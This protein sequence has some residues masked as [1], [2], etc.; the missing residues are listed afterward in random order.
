[1]RNLLISIR[2]LIL[3]TL[4]T[5]ILYPLSL[6]A[7]G[8]LFPSQAAGSLLRKDGRLVGSA[9]L[10]QKIESSRYFQPRPS[11]GDYATVASAASNLG[12]T[13]EVLAGA[14]ADRRAQWGADAPPDLLTTSGSGLDPHLSPAA[15]T[16]QLHRVAEARGIH[17]DRVLALIKKF[18]DGRQF[19]FLG[20]P[21]VRI[22][23]LNLALDDSPTQ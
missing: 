9:L 7:V 18:T 14:I 11:A 15:A 10:A 8:C 2:L 13:S 20:E 5:G 17:P 6:V 21:R 3:M 4:V 16:F 12:P 1:M 23:E 22:L 19:G